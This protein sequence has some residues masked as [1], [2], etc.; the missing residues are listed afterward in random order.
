MYSLLTKTLV[1]V[2]VPSQLLKKLVLV[3]PVQVL[4]EDGSREVF[5]IT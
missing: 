3:E 1:A 4:H 5:L 2:S